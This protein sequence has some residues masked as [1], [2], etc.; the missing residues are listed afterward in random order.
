MNR[1][2]EH[3]ALKTVALWALTLIGA[4]SAAYAVSRAIVSV[5]ARSTVYD[6][7]IVQLRRLAA[8][9]VAGLAEALDR[10]VVYI[11]AGEFI[12]GSDTGRSDERPQHPVYLDAFEMDR[13]EV[14]NAQYLRFL[15]AAGRLPPRYWPGDE[16]PT[17]Q[18]DYPV[19]GVS[20]Q[21][22]NDYC[23]WAGKRLPTE[24]EWE[25]ACRGA[26]AR[27]Y[28][29][30]NAWEPRRANI[31]IS[32]QTLRGASQTASESTVWDTAWQ[33]A[34]VTPQSGKPGLEPVGSHVDGAS[35]YGILDLAG[36]AS[37]WVADWYNWSDYARLPSHNPV[38]SGPSWNHC[39]RGSP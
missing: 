24:A 23:A 36:N 1:L 8:S 5:P 9:D 17:G 18:A 31:D 35:P 37:E 39:L 11:A 14:T 27:L 34:Q 10:C 33:L 4:L 19:V 15:R 13:Y 30:G 38:V 2:G 21:D 22:A 3:S 16:Y 29:W 20:W 32:I 26:D 12:M 28:P 6:A 7:E 25:K